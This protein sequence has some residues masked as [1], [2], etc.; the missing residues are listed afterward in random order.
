MS[1]ASVA[2]PRPLP[3]VSAG[4]RSESL[5]CGLH[6][7]PP[8]GLPQPP[9]TS[10]RGSVRLSASTGVRM[11]ASRWRAPLRRAPS[12]QR[13][14]RGGASGWTDRI[15]T[16]L[17]RRSSH[18]SHASTA[19]DSHVLV[20]IVQDR[21]GPANPFTFDRA[22]TRSWTDA[23]ITATSSPW[24]RFAPGRRTHGGPPELLHGGPSSCVAGP[25]PE[26]G[27][28]IRG[29]TQCQEPHTRGLAKMMPTIDRLGY[30]ARSF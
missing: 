5:T 24:A 2:N 18:S 9:A 16:V 21:P 30:D 1:I 8:A 15:R 10:R 13:P 22:A 11:T 6:P 14:Q 23:R 7:A 3:L 20:L 29:R 4:H 19:G 17:L 12:C 26:G 27:G 25:T 28:A